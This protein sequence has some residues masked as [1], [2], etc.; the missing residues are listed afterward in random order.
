M[1]DLYCVDKLKKA[2][3]NKYESGILN[4]LAIRADKTKWTCYPSRKSIAENTRNNI[5]TVDKYLKSLEKKGFIK[6]TRRARKTTLYE[7]LVHPDYPIDI[8]ESASG[9]DSSKDLCSMTHDN[10]S[11][12]PQN[13]ADESVSVQIGTLSTELENNKLE[14]DDR[15]KVFPIIRERFN[16]IYLE[17]CGGLDP[18][19]F[20]YLEKKRGYLE[21]GKRINSEED[22]RGYI[23][24]NYLT[25]G[26][27]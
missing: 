5:G 1:A 16:E 13:E 17:E 25:K 18:C 3:L 4:V 9:Q 24:D 6:R 10:D 8:D 26:G 21:N 27:G 7:V 20:N 19:L 23:K 12:T 11:F 14:R 15:E 2:N 22:L